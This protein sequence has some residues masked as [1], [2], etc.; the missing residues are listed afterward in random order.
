MPRDRNS[1]RDL[2]GQI[3]SGHISSWLMDLAIVSREIG[4]TEKKRNAKTCIGID[5]LRSGVSREH[6]DDD[7]LAPLVDVDQK[8][9]E[10]AIVFVDQID[11]I[12]TNLLERSHHGA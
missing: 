6:V 7:H 10:L 4:G 3:K 1:I 8:S 11:S 9:A 2:G 5:E 12:R